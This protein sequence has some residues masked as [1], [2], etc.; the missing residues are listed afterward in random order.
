MST[1][2]SIATTKRDKVGSANARRLRRT[3]Q[4]P[5]VVYSKAEKGSVSIHLQLAEGDVAKIAH[6]AGL[7]E[8]AVE[9]GT[10]YNVITKEIQ[11]HPISSRPLSVEFQE[12]KAGQTVTVTVPVEAH[13]E[14]A[15]L[16]QGGQLEQV[17][18]TLVITAA[19]QDIPEV[20]VVDVSGIELDQAL[21]VADI[22]LNGTAKID[23]DPQLIVFHVRKPHTKS[24]EAE[25]AAP[26][27]EGEAAAAAPA[28]DAEK[29]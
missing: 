9:D 16:K 8:L 29:K 26:A 13:G 3:G 10:K 24:T 5:V 7:V 2:I 11:F 22:K 25:T 27:A 12:V 17:L 15:G 28:A 4:V 19:P 1:S 23:E 20:V 21:T 14:P 6:H 18:H